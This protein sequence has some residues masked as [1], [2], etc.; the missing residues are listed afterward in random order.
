M[1]YAAEVQAF[2]QTFRDVTGREPSGDL[3]KDADVLS[4]YGENAF[5]DMGYAD[6]VR[7]F[8][9][10]FREVTGREPSGDLVKDA[11]ILSHYGEN[12]LTD[13]G[14]A[15]EVQAFEQTFREG[16]RVGNPP[17]TWLKTPTF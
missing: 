10:T 9:K 16:L 7:A 15:A 14:Y 2:E 11:D 3:V 5:T 13:M 8:E 4:R 12:A 1:G 17:A 6:D